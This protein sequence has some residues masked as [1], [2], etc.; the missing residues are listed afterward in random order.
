MSWFPPV[1]SDGGGFLWWGHLSLRQAGVRQ[2]RDGPE[3]SGKTGPSESPAPSNPPD[4]LTWGLNC[5]EI[6]RHPASAALLAARAQTLSR[7]E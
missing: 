3:A 7:M 6:A 2:A 4:A 5:R 1:F